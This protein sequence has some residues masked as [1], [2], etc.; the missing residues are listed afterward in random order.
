M[1]TSP[2][3]T[4]RPP[5]RG[6]VPG[7]AR[8][9][10]ITGRGSVTAEALIGA[11]RPNAPEAKRLATM[12]SDVNDVSDVRN[13]RTADRFRCSISYGDRAR[14]SNPPIAMARPPSG[15]QMPGQRWAILPSPVWGSR[16]AGRADKTSN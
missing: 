1:P 5:L 7:V 15:H 16:T 10:K 8:A 14:Q 13:L 6:N 9:E 12:A 3:T 11:A 4:T 2:V